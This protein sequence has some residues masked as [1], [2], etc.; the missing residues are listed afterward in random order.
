MTG[1]FRL[2]PGLERELAEIRESWRPLRQAVARDWDRVLGTGPTP[3]AFRLA[4]QVAD[5]MAGPT[6]AER[7]A[8]LVPL[9]RAAAAEVPTGVLDGHVR[10]LVA[11]SV[12]WV[13]DS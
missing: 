4:E 1:G 10:D 9:I 5:R 13:P 6:V 7:A 8:A 3:V 11:G 2:P 12:E